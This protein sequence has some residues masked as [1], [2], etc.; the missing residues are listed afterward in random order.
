MVIAA[1]ESSVVNAACLATTTVFRVLNPFF[2]RPEF[3]SDMQYK[4]LYGLLAGWIRERFWPGWLGPT[5]TSYFSADNDAVFEKCH[6][7][8]GISKAMWRRFWLHL[9]LLTTGPEQ[10]NENNIPRFVYSKNN[11]PS[12]GNFIQ[13]LILYYCMCMCRSVFNWYIFRSYVLRLL[14]QLPPPLKATPLQKG[15][16]AVSG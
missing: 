1:I 14:V 8:I 5:A 2:Y 13:L 7:V 9:K 3:L 6:C 11:Y 15:T 16:S 12:R 4:E 10:L